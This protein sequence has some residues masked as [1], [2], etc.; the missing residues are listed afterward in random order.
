MSGQ[1]CDLGQVGSLIIVSEQV[2]H[3]GPFYLF[4]II[5]CNCILKF[6]ICLLHA[7]LT[8]CCCLKLIRKIAVVIW[9]HG[10]QRVYCTR[11]FCCQLVWKSDPFN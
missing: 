7:V 8:I 5:Q 6:I 11:C 2:C 1:V 4:S 9:T 3:G 10:M